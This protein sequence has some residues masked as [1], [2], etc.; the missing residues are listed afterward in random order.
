[1]FSPEQK[2]SCGY[3]EAKSMPHNEKEDRGN[4][5]GKRISHEG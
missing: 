2:D 4:F 3:Y 1:M 5:E